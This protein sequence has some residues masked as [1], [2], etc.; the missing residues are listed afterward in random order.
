MRT[1]REKTFLAIILLAGLAWPV[2]GSGLRAELVSLDYEATVA[3]VVNTPFGLTLPLG[4]T[5]RGFFTYQTDSGDSNASADRGDYPRNLGSAFL[6]RLPGV[7]ITGSGT[8]FLRTENLTSDAFRFTD[9][10]EI[11]DRAGIMKLDGVADASL[12]LGLA[13]TDSTGTAFSNDALPAIFPWRLC[14]FNGS[15]PSGP[16][17]TFRLE[18]ATGAVLLQFKSL[19]QRRGLVIRLDWPTAAEL[20]WTSTPGLVYRVETS[21]DGRDW[22]TSASGIPAQGSTTIW[23]DDLVG[24]FPGGPPPALLY[25]VANP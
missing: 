25:R 19:V 10:P 20:V 12:K 23:T 3:T 1:D 7:T 13:I 22:R 8:A 16:P 6:A 9:G 2:G 17:H 24:R 11:F 14:A 4:T 15:A 5:V 21:T 18:D